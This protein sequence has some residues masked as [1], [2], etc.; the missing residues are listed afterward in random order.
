MFEIKKKSTLTIKTSTG[1]ERQTF[2]YYELANKW[3]V[4][5]S[6]KASNTASIFESEHD[7]KDDSL[8]LGIRYQGTITYVYMYHN[9]ASIEDIPY[10]IESVAINVAEKKITF[11]IATDLE[12]E[13]SEIYI[14]K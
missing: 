8:T 5:L 13:D 9:S 3:I 14:N 10:T 4:G 7:V 2:N 12:N 11:L 6:E 1:F